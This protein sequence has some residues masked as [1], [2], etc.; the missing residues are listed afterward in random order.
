MEERSRDA[1]ASG[2]LTAGR[3]ITVSRFAALSFARQLEDATVAKVGVAT[4]TGDGGVFE[5]RESQRV[6]MWQL[7][8]RRWQ[9]WKYYCLLLCTTTAG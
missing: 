4:A 3:R 1:D 7:G 8:G 2:D 6:R 5:F 9:W